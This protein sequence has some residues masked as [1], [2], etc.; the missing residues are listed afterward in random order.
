MSSVTQRESKG[1]A[2]VTGA[3]QG[4]GRAVALRLASDGFDVAVNDIPSKS[5]QLEAVK[6]EVIAAGRG[7]AVFIGDVSVDADV[8]A[9]V[10]GVV[11]TFGGL[12]VMVANAAISPPRASLLDTEPEDWDRT[13]A[14]NVRGTFL[15]YKH[16]AKQ[17]VLQGRG[18][19]IIGACS[20][21]GKQAQPGLPDYSA[22]KFAVRGLT[23]AAALD[24]GKHGITINAYAP[25]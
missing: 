8:K 21:A 2:I 25:L 20:G 18:G 1:V 11:A 7:T 13:F 4:I 5:A 23:Q 16:T 6:A 15:F 22:S 12:D 24:F 3:A 17:M 19:R 10:A 14:I 9:L